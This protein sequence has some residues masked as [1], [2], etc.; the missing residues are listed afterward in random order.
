MIWEVL[1]S[2]Y[3]EWLADYTKSI[4]SRR[5]RNGFTDFPASPDKLNGWL[6]ENK[7]A[8]HFELLWAFA[9]DQAER[10]SQSGQT[11]Y[12]YDPLD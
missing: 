6:T 4:A 11:L 7:T 2:C 12:H 8:I 5:S 9:E 10:P 3:E 1:H